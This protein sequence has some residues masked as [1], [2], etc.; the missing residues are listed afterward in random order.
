MTRVDTIRSDTTLPERRSA[1]MRAVERVAS[2]P[3]HRLFLMLA[4]PVGVFLVFAQPPGQG[5]DEAAH[6][7]RVWTL[8]DGALFATTQHGQTGGN[9]PQ[10]LPAYLDRFSNRAAQRGPFDFASFWQTASN[11]SEKPVFASFANTAVYSPVAY[12]PPLVAVAFLRGVHSPLPL[13]FF[14]GRLASLVAFLV[15]FS[16]AIRLTPV[17]KEVMVVV[18]LL[19]TS[20][21]LVSCYSED[22]M[23]IA[24]AALAVALTLRCCR[25]PHVSTVEF[26]CLGV[27]L[28]ALTL[29]KP[30]FLV[31]VPLLYLVPSAV[32]PFRH[33]VLVKSGS[34]LVIVVLGGLWYLAVRHALEVPVRLYAIY[35]HRQ[36]QHILHD[37]LGFLATVGRTLFD[38]SG[39][40][41]WLP[42]FFFSIG[43]QRPP[44]ADDI[45]AGPLLV[46]VGAL[47][48][49]YSYWLQFGA[50]R[51]KVARMS[52][53]WSAWAPIGLMVAGIL[54]INASLYIYGTPL[55]FP[56]IL[57][58]GRYLYPLVLLPLITIGLFKE[59]RTLARSTCWIASGSSAMLVWLILKVFVHDYSL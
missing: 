39:K 58:Q 11:H 30:T 41:R 25:S 32:L 43:Y 33:S 1:P 57:I 27:A 34:A 59:P 53:K 7:E 9:V 21:L 4:L 13:V 55:G 12:V 29:M 47:T 23:T 22:P 40:E 16:L 31:F 38:R 44:P 50:N 28:L 35:P 14:A 51:L 42:G 2:I 56:E 19:P 18:G 15:L 17:G 8:S 48:F 10:T 49:L 6:F 20:M 3:L 52:V 46:I 37:P 24:F 54:F 26:G 45:Y 36:E 5:L